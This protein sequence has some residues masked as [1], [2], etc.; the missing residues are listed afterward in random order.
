M[1][2]PKA[3]GMIFVLDSGNCNLGSVTRALDKLSLKYA[4]VSQRGDLNALSPAD[5]L[6]LPGVGSFG[7]FMERLADR[8][9]VLPIRNFGAFGGKIFGICVGFQSLFEGSAESP[10]VDG[11]AL[12]KGSFVRMP[13]P[14]LPSVGFF[15][16]KNHDV[17]QQFYFTHSYGILLPASDAL[18]PMNNN[19]IY[20]PRENI[21]VLAG[22][23]DGQV[24]GVQFHPEKSG[25]QGLS[26]LNHE[27][28]KHNRKTPEKD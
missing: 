2:K 19:L 27:L 22:V 10:H 7:A 1:V 17:N 5:V 9:L 23:T 12:L 28:N 21:D 14:V 13:L 20:C 8:D 6:V 16:L 4:V 24:A 25:V 3:K 11:L 26:F 18:E 15:P